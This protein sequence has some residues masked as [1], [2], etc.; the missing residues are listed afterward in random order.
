MNRDR[1]RAWST[2]ALAIVPVA[3]AALAGCGVSKTDYQ[4]KVQEASTAKQLQ[5]RFIRR[6]RVSAQE[7]AESLALARQTLCLGPVRHDT[8][9]GCA[10]TEQVHLPHAHGTRILLAQ[11]H[12][13]IE[14]GGESGAI[15][16]D[17]IQAA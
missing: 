5:I 16:P 7:Q 12:R 15:R 8:V 13:T 14:F 11:M 4:A 2:L 10:Q 9:R 1:N 3:F 17:P 6:D